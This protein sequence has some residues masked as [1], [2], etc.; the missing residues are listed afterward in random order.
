MYELS[1]FIKSPINNLHQIK[2]KK[3]YSMQVE[4]LKIYLLKLDQNYF[5][6]CNINSTFITRGDLV[7][8]IIGLLMLMVN[9]SLTAFADT[10]FGQLIVGG[11]K[12]EKG[13]FP[14]QV[15]LQS[16]S[17]S[18]FCGGSLIK[19]NWVLTAAHCTQGSSK[20]KIVVGL[21]DQKDKL[22][23]EVFSA[24]KII[25]HPDFNS[26]TLDSDYALIKLSGNSTF[27]P[28]ELNRIEITI[29]T[30]EEKFNVWTS[31]WG[32]TS[33]GSFSLPNILNKVEVPLVTTEECN[34]AKAYDG[35]ITN[36]M[37]CAGLKEGGKDSCQGDSGGPMFKKDNNGEFKLIGVVSWGEG[38]ARPNKYGVYSKVNAMTEWIDLQV[39]Q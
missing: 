34:S 25:R 30:G 21:H 13:E 32:A 4:F 37:M 3:I 33:E 1:I 18:H 14:F 31:G 15:S 24:T 5:L 28:I 16:S 29:P 12:A 35:A 22:G 27:K 20:F 26:S 10:Q 11:V 19:P 17:G 6:V 39:Q 36:H 38:C 9:L 23:T 8:K 2:P 7:I